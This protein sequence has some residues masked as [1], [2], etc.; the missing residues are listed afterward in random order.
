MSTFFDQIEELN[1]IPEFNLKYVQTVL[2]LII[3]KVLDLDEV[4]VGVFNDGHG[5]FGSLITFT[6][7]DFET[8]VIDLRCSS[9][10]YYLTINDNSENP[11]TGTFRYCLSD[12]PA[13]IETIPEGL[14]EFMEMVAFER[15]ETVLRPKTLQ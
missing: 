13:L 1:R 6:V 2:K 7:D 4:D 3:S 8:V 14:R 12:N 15:E 9:N 11:G 10:S 5:T